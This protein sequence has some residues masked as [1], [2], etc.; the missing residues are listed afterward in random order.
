MIVGITNLNSLK[1]IFTE[2]FLSFVQSPGGIIF[3]LRSHQ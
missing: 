3:N 2:Y 1:I